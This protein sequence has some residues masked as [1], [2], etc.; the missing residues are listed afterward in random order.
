M[1][2]QMLFSKLLEGTQYTLLIFILTLVFSL[3]LGM[4]LCLGRMSKHKV[5]QL[6]I[7]LYLLIMRGT[8][9]ML[10]LMFVFFGLPKLFSVFDLRLDRFVACIIAFAL[11]YAAYFAE[12][13]RG[14]MEAVPNGQYEAAKVLG[15]T[16]KQTFF[17]IVLPQV[18]KRIVPPMGN[19][20]ITLV[21]DTSLA[22][23]ISVTELMYYTKSL[24]DSMANII[25]FL[26]A[27]VFYLI[28]N[29]LL[30]LLLSYLEKKLSYYR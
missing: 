9:L 15:F 20:L 7:K 24:V 18:I 1:N 5:L 17:Q 16:K 27:A 22:T 26:F 13:F 6:P 21:K 23:V 28:M 25:P 14:G 3:P 30:T 10:Q 4:L 2:Y 12:I 11:N 8:P 19:E 29:G